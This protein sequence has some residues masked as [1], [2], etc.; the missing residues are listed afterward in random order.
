MPILLSRR[1]PP[2]SQE[3]F[4][5]IDYNV[6][7]LAFT[8][9]RDLGPFLFDEKIYQHELAWR[10]RQAGLDAAMEE[11]IEVRFESFST[12]YSIDLLVNGS[13]LYELKAVTALNEHHRR[14]AIGG[15][16]SQSQQSFSEVS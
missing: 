14:Q 1:F 7:G 2:I 8:V 4:N 11:P 5:E 12:S 9:H 16:P 10:C 15:P 3:E 6:T 13:A